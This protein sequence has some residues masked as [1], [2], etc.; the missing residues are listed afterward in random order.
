MTISEFARI[1]GIKRTNLIFYD[2]IG[3]LAP[4]HRGENGY[5]YYSRN[6]LG[7]GFLI[8]D[9]RKIGIGIEEIKAYAK[10]RTPQKMLEL[11][12][13][14]EKAIENE[15]KKLEEI[16]KMM[17]LQIK[18]VEGVL[19]TDIK[20]FQTVKREAE[21]ILLG[22]TIEKEIVDDDESIKFYNYAAE[23][24]IDLGYPFGAIIGKENLLKG[25]IENAKC[26]YFKMPEI[27][28]ST[29]EKPA[30][31]Y[32]MG[33]HH[34]NYGESNILYQG[35]LDYIEE[36]NLKILGDAYEEYPLNE[37]ST[38]KTEN[39]LVKVEIMVG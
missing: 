33:F 13:A 5:R 25:K 7:S 2:Q 14:K 1:T 21:P 3:L 26:F 34:G 6:Q 18:T 17:R 15:I 22:P 19:K 11:F 35:M 39:Y 36:K 23:K 8:N 24:G 10:D 32:L 38:L 27:S 9:L 20:V 31:I 29:K 37:I 12:K 28:E 4:E 30:G 16:K